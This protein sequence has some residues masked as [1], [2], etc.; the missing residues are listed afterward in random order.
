MIICSKCGYENPDHYEVC[1]NCLINLEWSRI[2]LGRFTGSLED[3][4]QIGKNSR[5]SLGEDKVRCIKCGFQ[6]EIDIK[7]NECPNCG[8]DFF[9]PFSSKQEEMLTFEGKKKCPFCAEQIQ[10]EAIVCRYCGRDLDE[11]TRRKQSPIWKKAIVIGIVLGLLGSIPSFSDLIQ[12][13][14]LILQGE[15]NILAFRA[16]LNNFVFHLCGNLLIWPIIIAIVIWVWRKI[17]AA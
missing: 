5:V 12:V 3:T 13:Q 10:A 15:L 9:T 7:G 6:W 4:I 16:A 17:E 14:E 1:A 8:L 11:S 2:N